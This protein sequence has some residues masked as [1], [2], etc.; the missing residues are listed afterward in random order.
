MLFQFPLPLSFIPREQFFVNNI[1]WFNLIIMHYN[2]TTLHIRDN[3]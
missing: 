3:W 1:Q 2:N